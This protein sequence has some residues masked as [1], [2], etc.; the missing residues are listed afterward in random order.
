M[1]VKVKTKVSLNHKLIDE[2]EHG[3]KRRALEKTAE[4]VLS[5][6]IASA[7][8]PKDT[9]ELERSGFVRII[10]DTLAKVI[11][12]TPYARRWYYNADG[13][14]FST[15]KNINAQDHWMDDFIHG[16]R[17][18]EIIEK[19]AEFYKEELGRVFS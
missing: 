8:V 11:F 19:F 10:S 15:D 9:G 17:T 5:E 18:H 6:I 4:W 2:M 3:A 16:E 7:K 1:K 13:V 12:D 14:T